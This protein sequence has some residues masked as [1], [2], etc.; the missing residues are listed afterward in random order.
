MLQA[1]AV[2]A[3][4]GAETEQAVLPDYGESMNTTQLYIILLGA[5]L[6]ISLFI[7]CIYLTLPHHN[8]SRFLAINSTRLNESTCRY[9]WL[10]GTD[11]DS[12]V[13]NI[14]IDNISVGH[15]KVMSVIHV[16]NCSAVVRM[17]MKDVKAWVQLYPKAGGI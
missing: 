10:G 5:F 9:T 2:Y 14:S 15:P 4:A 16:G 8:A 13:G 12:F 3:V 11:Y 6:F 17:Y 7:L 1:R